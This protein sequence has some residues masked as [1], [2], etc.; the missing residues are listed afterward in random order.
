MRN[1][2]KPHL[3]C[4]IIFMTIKHISPKIHITVIKKKNNNLTF[5]IVMLNNLYIIVIII[6]TFNFCWFK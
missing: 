5:I 1:K 4:D 6:N 3:H 2:I